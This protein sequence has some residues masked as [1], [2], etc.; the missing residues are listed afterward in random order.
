MIKKIPKENI[1]DALRK[2]YSDVDYLNV[3]YNSNYIIVK[4]FHS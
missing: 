4:W 1:K 3:T 2:T